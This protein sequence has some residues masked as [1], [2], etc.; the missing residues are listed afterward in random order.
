MNITAKQYAQSLYEVVKGKKD[1]Q[2]KEAIKNFFRILV[3]NNDIFKIDK[4]VANFTEIWNREEGI[5]AAK[6]ISA[7]KFDNKIINSLNNYII[8]LSKAKRTEIR[9]IVDKNILGG[10]II[11]YEDKIIDGSL[12][13]RLADLKNKM[14]K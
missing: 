7:R 8:K 5:V 13:T 14:V 9:Q 10:V 11:R 2:I 4:I 12:R 6:I 3:N 1:S